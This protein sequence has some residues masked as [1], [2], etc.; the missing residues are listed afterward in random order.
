MGPWRTEAPARQV[1]VD[2]D[3]REAALLCALDPVRSVL[4]AARIEAAIAGGARHGGRTLWGVERAGRLVA[5]CWAGANLVPVCDADD[6]AALDAFAE[7]AIRQ[8]RRCSSIV[9]EAGA[10]L[11]LWRR[12]Q[13]AWGTAREVRQ[14][15][16]S[17]VIDHPPL[18]AP[19]P[20][21]RLS[22]VSEM[23]VLMP[24]CV[25]MFVEEVGYSPL[26]GNPGAYEA[27]VRGLV[28]DGRSFV[29]IEEG[30]AGPE[31]AFKA[32]LGAVSAAVA[33]VQ[34]V[35]VP[36]SRRGR[37]LATAG[38]AAVVTQTLATVAP[39]VSLYVNHYNTRALATYERVGFRQVGTYATVLF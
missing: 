15:Q 19:D 18:V 25:Q 39:L 23:G 26:Q 17:M 5:L 1:V 6:T 13:P 34:G 28:E 35:W 22:R 14:D 2:V 4:A 7:A 27:R 8:G 12:L 37:G 10:V 9:G 21:V 38:M 24:A 36:P 11:A 29:R 32:E 20:D 16:P 31:V 3:L 33:Q 30:S